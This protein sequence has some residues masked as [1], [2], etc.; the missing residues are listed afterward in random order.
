[1]NR[2]EAD[3]HWE[4]IL[5]KCISI[6]TSYRGDKGTQQSVIWGGSALRSSPLS[7]II[8]TVFDSKGTSF[9]V[10]LLLTNEAPNHIP[11]LEL[12]IPFNRS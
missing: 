3:L 1:M 6:H 5:K 8:Y 10:Y 11:S 2:E 12:C 9:A 7:F 4:L